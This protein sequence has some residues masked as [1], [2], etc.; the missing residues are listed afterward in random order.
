MKLLAEIK[1]R[2]VLKVA[3]IYLGA[4]WLVAELGNTLFE[5]FQLPRVALQLV[6]VLLVLGFP[7]ALV[8]A[9]F[10]GF[11][12]KLDHGE[13]GAGE[14]LSDGNI[15]I[16]AVGLTLVTVLAAVIA[17]RYVHIGR[18]AS[19]PPI[20][21][22]ADAPASAATS[23]A[24]PDDAFKPPPRSV[25]VLPF[26]NMSG[27]A[28]DEYFSDG[29]SEELLNS[30]VRVETLQVAARTS[31]FAFKGK[32]ADVG[33]IARRLNVGNVLEGSVRKAGERLRITAQLINAVSGFHV[34]SETYDRDL[35]DIFALQTE[36]A[37]AVTNAMRVTLIDGGVAKLELGGT[38]DPQAFDDYLHGTKLSR[39]GSEADDRA[40]LAA[41]GAAT[42]RDPAYALA[43]AAHS[44]A[45]TEFASRW[46][47]PIGT[48]KENF[49][50]ARRSAERAL[51]LAPELGKAHLA[52]GHVL[53]YGY[54]DFPAAIAAQERA[55]ALTPGDAEAQRTVASSLS[56]RGHT[57][58]SIVAARRAVTLDPLNPLS[59][60]TLG[61]VLRNAVRLDE[62]R[63]AF[64]QGQIVDPDYADNFTWVAFLDLD[65]GDAQRA[66]RS[67]VHKDDYFQQT[68]LAIAFHKAGRKAESDAELAKV[69][70]LGD[71]AAFQVTQIY[72]QRGE[73]QVALEWLARAYRVRDP[74]II[75]MGVEPLLAPIRNAPEFKR[76]LAELKLP[77]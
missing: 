40:A 38:K 21:A 65:A 5:V 4:S 29:L 69:L 32:D 50:V 56:W 52:L 3:T 63:A 14:R 57:E 49:A 23:P 66:A 31:S 76:V 1:N 58:E 18:S 36:I 61:Q 27:D 35:K 37:T 55:I 6:I 74:G 46:P 67:C 75:A 13:T 53:D 33:T 28:K 7:V 26:V 59:Y 9:W 30:L 39:G 15:R 19:D 77:D 8:A 12:R 54:F 34:W 11:G 17:V 43:W 10:Y 70:A 73:I 68:C 51:A 72:A 71:I 45:Q 24:A 41:F 64:R 2:G 42:T 16:I 60:K 44:Y 47:S 20:T 22:A 48:M 25:A 62:A